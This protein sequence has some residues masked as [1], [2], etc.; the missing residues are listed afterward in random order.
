MAM[1]TNTEA[2]VFIPELW[3][4]KVLS[5]REDALLMP[6]RVL[7]ALDGLESKVKGDLINIPFLSNLES[8]PVGSKGEITYQ[9]VTETEIEVALDQWE[10]SAFKISDRTRAQANIDLVDKY[11]AKLAFAQAKKVETSL[12]GLYSGLSQMTDSIDNMDEE[13]F[14]RAVQYLDDAIVPA[15]D[16]H[17]IIK[18]GQK[19][20]LMRLASWTHADIL[21]ASK[22]DSPLRT[23][24]LLPE[25]GG[26]EILMSALVIRTGGVSYNLMWHNEAFALALQQKVKT[27]FLARV[28]L[29]TP[30]VA[31]QLFGYK[32]ARDNHAVSIRTTVS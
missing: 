24:K 17:M 18:P 10:H 13:T 3:S 12:L 27:E 4:P 32:G 5:A 9:A 2:D 1:I 16:R 15:T 25:Y 28:E 11:T 6:K 23:G 19:K 26:I 31:W 7:N 14:L 29:A 22:S 20:A 8:Y 21:A 30:V